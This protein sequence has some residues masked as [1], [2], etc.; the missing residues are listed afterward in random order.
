MPTDPRIDAYI[1]SARPFA[2]PILTFIRKAV[3]AGCPEVEETLKWSRPAFMYKGILCGMAAFK[4]HV[5]FGFWN[6]AMNAPGSRN[7]ALGP[8]FERIAS[9]AD[10]PDR[11]TLVGLVEE[12]AAVQ[13]QGVKAPRVK[14]A[15]R[16]PLAEPED[17]TAAL[18]KNRKARAAYAAFSPSH[19]REYIEGITEAK[20][21]ATRTRRLQTAL[22]WMADGKPRNWKYM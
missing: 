7:S 16:T 10:L 8:Q 5:T 3:H 13:D 6:A 17:L 9:V 15:P 4:E 21:E 22:D 18:A 19:K 20:T 1:A 11:K 14:R 2:R 12:A